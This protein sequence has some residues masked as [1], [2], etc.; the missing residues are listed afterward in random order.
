MAFSDPFRLDEK[1]LFIAGGS[2]GLGREMALAIASADADVCLVA[3]A[4]E[5]LH[6]TADDG[7]LASSERQV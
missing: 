6:K 7:P 4:S 5:S 2:R 1:K 3:R